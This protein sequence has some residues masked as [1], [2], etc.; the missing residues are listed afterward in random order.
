MVLGDSLHLM[1]VWV[2]QTA[3]H[4]D[5]VH[6]SSSTAAEPVSSQRC[7]PVHCTII[8]NLNVNVILYC[9]MYVMTDHLWINFDL[10]HLYSVPSCTE[11]I[12]DKAMFI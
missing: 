2:R 4:K 3:E 8:Y 9:F 10:Y 7:L 11:N 6:T 5:T 12:Q 1:L